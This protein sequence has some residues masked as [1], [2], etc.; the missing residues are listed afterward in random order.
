MFSH[1]L[2]LYNKNRHLLLSRGFSMVELM[3]SISIIVMVLTITMSRQSS[4]NSAVLLR[5]EAFD[6]ALAIREVQLSA[7]SAA[8]D[9]GGEFRNRLGVYFDTDTANTYVFFRDNGDNFYSPTGTDTMYG[10]RGIIDPRFVISAITPDSDSLTSNND[11]SIVFERPNFDARFFKAANNDLTA[12]RVLIRISLAG[13][14]GSDCGSDFRDVEI[15][16]AG[17]ISVVNCP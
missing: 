15:T 16:S 6:L 3:V 12:S 2:A 9:G 13:A 10:V 8:S 4:F 14:T 1:F 17:Q 7:V 11:L 5:S